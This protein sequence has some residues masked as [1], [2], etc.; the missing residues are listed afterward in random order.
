MLETKVSNIQL[1][2]VA[3]PFF[4]QTARVAKYILTVVRPALSF[5]TAL[6]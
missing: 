2:K 6:L 4:Y 1:Q 3:Y 5:G